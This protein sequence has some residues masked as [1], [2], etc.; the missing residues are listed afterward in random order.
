VQDQYFWYYLDKYTYKER[1]LLIA[2]EIEFRIFA[3]N[4][5]VNFFYSSCSSELELGCFEREKLARLS[6]S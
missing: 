1:H 2:G 5:R 4:G 3:T 6:E